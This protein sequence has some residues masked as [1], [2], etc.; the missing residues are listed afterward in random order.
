[1]TASASSL[2]PAL[3]ERIGWSLVHSVWQ[4]AAVAVVAVGVLRMLRRSP[5][6]SRYLTACG[7]LV[8]MAILPLTT[9]VMLGIPDDS[10]V[11]LSVI[12]SR[13]VTGPMPAPAGDSR[14]NQTEAFKSDLRRP[15][16]PANPAS[17]GMRRLAQCE[18]ARSSRYS[19][20]WW[21]PGAWAFL[22][23]PCGSSGVGY[24]FSGEWHEDDPK[25]CH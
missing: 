15:K 10:G 5:A 20:G 21:A 23:S 7:A 3:I 22:G 17:I 16:T 1:M 11:K 25:L 12:A 9:F 4:V 19:P 6:L 24:G 18:A 8:T 13:S 2:G 14:A